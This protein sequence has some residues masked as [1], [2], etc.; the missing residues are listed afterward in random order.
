[1]AVNFAIR[2]TTNVRD[3]RK[4][5]RRRESHTVCLLMQAQNSTYVCILT[6]TFMLV[7]GASTTGDP[8]SSTRRWP[9]KSICIWRSS[10]GGASLPTRS[11]TGFVVTRVQPGAPND[12][13]P[14]QGGQRRSKEG[15]FARLVCQHRADATPTF[16]FGE[17]VQV[18][19]QA[20]LMARREILPLIHSCLL[21]RLLLDGLSPFLIRF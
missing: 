7:K 20:V 5:I 15:R 10:G 1:M 8:W 16:S 17:E 2:Q 19:R 12:Q 3:C 14:A 18:V 6:W 11:I 4:S 13:L 21:V 9:P